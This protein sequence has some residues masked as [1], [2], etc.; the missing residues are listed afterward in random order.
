MNAVERLDPDMKN[1]TVQKL[2]SRIPAGRVARNDIEA[3]LADCM[4]ED[5]YSIL[6]T[7]RLRLS[8]VS[9]RSDGHREILGVAKGLKENAER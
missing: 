4:P 2:S 7:K 6:G 9:V 1:G 3:H 5:R 8:S